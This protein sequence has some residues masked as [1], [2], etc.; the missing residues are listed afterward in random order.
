MR[1]HAQG[2]RVQPLQKQKAVEGGERASQAAQQNDARTEDIG[3]SFKIER[4]VLDELGEDDALVVGIGGIEGGKTFGVLS[5][6]EVS[7]VYDSTSD[8]VGVSADVLRHRIDNDMRPQQERATE[9]GSGGV[10]DDEGDAHLLAY[11]ADF[12]DGKGS[13]IRVRQC[14]AVEG[15]GAF[16]AGVA[17]SFGVVWIDEA[18]FDPH[19][20][21]TVCKKVSNPSVEHLRAYDVVSVSRDVLKGISDSSLS[22]AHGERA[23]S[24]FKACKAFFEDGGGRVVEAR[25]DVASFFEGEKAS[26]LRSIVELVGDRLVE[27]G[28]G[29]ACRRIAAVG[30]VQRARGGLP[31]G[32]VM[33]RERHGSCDSVRVP[34]GEGI[35]GQWGGNRKC[36]FGS[37]LTERGCFDRTPHA[38]PV[39]HFFYT[40]LPSSCYNRQ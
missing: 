12:L 24:S 38:H 26:G 20:S 33:S 19:V 29:G 1:L 34:C 8:G 37:F 40:T 17:E 4:R 28:R 2:Q 10:V 27:G 15:A 5:P 9:D 6:V 7:S 22:R 11:L 30:G 13:E 18:N 31:S 25:V 14:F 32:I 23:R 36:F 39:Q 16:V 3:A 21:E 35:L